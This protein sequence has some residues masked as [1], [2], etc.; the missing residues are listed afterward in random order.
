VIIIGLIAAPAHAHRSQHQ[1]A[2]AT[3]FKRFACLDHRN[4][5]SVLFNNE[6]LDG[7]RIAGSD[8]GIGILKAKRHRF[9][10]DNV[11]ACFGGRNGVSRMHAAGC[12]HRHRI[13]TFLAKKLIDIV[14]CRYPE[15]GSD[16]VGA[17]RQ[18]VAH[19]NQFG[20]GDMAASKEIGVAFRDSSAPQQAK[21]DHASPC[22]FAPADRTMGI[23]TT[24][25]ISRDNPTTS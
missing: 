19:G 20:S 14:E 21:L 3:G 18:L 5:E 22:Q 2:K 15:S 11:L 7:R 8:H 9:F 1:P 6:Q 17:L 13:E 23:R 16:G 24:Y 12:Q 10:N 25:P 4:V